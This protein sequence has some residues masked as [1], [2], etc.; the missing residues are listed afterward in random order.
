MSLQTH[1]ILGHQLCLHEKECKRGA[2]VEAAA[3]TAH[4]TTQ[5]YNLFIY[6]VQK[7]KQNTLQKAET[8][9]LYA[10]VA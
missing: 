4:P 9:Q 3:L 2:V 6:K 7:R 1:R 8:Q 10:A 5:S